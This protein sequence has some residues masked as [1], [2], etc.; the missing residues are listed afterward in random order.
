M[1]KGL[2]GLSLSLCAMLLLAGCSCKK[3]E[4]DNSVKADIKDGSSEVLSGLKEDTKKLTLQNL[5]DDLKATYGNEV[6]ADKLIE[7]IADAEIT[8]E[9]VGRYAAKIE[10]KMMELV[11]NEAYQVNGE[12][13]EELLV[14]DLRAQLY[15]ID[16]TNAN[17][18]GPT[19]KAPE[20]TG[21]PE[22]VVVD[23]YLLCNYK[24]YQEK[25]L[26]LEVLKELLNEKYVYEEVLKEKETLFKTKKA[27]LVEYITIDTSKD[28]SFE[29]ITDAVESLKN[30][31]S[32]ENI[33][34]DWKGKLVEE[35]EEK[36]NKIGTKDDSTGT[37]MQEFTGE[38]KYDKE[39]GRR[40]KTKEIYDGVYYNRTIITTDSKDI[41]NTTLVD[42]LLSENV[43]PTSEEDKSNKTIKI[44]DSYYLV[45]PLAGANPDE[46][47]IRITDK[48]NSKYY[49]VKV[50]KVDYNKNETVQTKKDLAYEVVKILAQNSSLVSNSLNYY[51][52]QNKDAISVHDEEIYTYLKTQY[53]DIFVD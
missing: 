5:Y 29:F 24:D 51:L 19:Y 2:K 35:L 53:A 18:F 16:C 47:D 25:A 33:A 4:D 39:E 15:N 3:D 31:E 13:S 23:K 1:R 12:F 17:G 32:L 37:I 36:F 8:E 45:S 48:T 46:D 52:E 11:K 27:R 26:R 49:I 21:D 50:E 7:I 30:G 22:N 6:A 38:Y 10:E 40:L 34:E 20:N 42:I 14:A 9:W 28:F 44:N 43:I 41:L